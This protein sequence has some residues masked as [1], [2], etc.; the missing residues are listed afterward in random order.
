[1]KGGSL[2]VLPGGSAFDT[3]SEGLVSS[4][5]TLVV[6]SGQSASGVVV[7]SGGTIELL[8]G[9][10]VIGLALQSGA[11]EEI[12]AGYELDNLHRQQRHYARSRT[13]RHCQQCHRAVRRHA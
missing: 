9:A 6:S 1:M 7:L 8:S 3:M 5:Q 10:T 2:M 4:G 12:A 13:R 11:T